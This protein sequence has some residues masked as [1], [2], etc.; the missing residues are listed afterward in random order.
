MLETPLED[1]FAHNKNQVCSIPNVENNLKILK[2]L[3]GDMV[4]KDKLSCYFGG[5]SFNPFISKKWNNLNKVKLTR[6]AVS[7]YNTLFRKGWS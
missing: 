5:Y 1:G 3:W 7:N 6:R 4:E 2:K